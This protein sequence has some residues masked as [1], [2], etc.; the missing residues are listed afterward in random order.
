MLLRSVSQIPPGGF[1][2]LS[3]FQILKK[4]NVRQTHLTKYVQN[5]QN[6]ESAHMETM[7]L[8]VVECNDVTVHEE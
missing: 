2:K 6:D 8:A 7:S 1:L 5:L 4:T 3:V